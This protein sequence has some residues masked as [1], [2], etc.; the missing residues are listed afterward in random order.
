MKTKEEKMPVFVILAKDMCSLS[1]I[2]SY[3][4]ACY[5]AKVSKQAQMIIK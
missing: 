5:A 1:A 4:Q 3:I 2:T